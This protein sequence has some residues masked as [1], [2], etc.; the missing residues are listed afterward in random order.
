[1]RDG[2]A[3]FKQPHRS[4]V[5][6]VP[7]NSLIKLFTQV[8]VL[9]AHKTV[10]IDKEILQ[11]CAAELAAEVC[12]SSTAEQLVYTIQQLLLNKKGQKY[13]DELDRLLLKNGKTKTAFFQCL[14]ANWA[15]MHSNGTVTVDTDK[16]QAA[17]AYIDE[18]SMT[19]SLHH[20]CARVLQLLYKHYFSKGK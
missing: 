2:C 11:S 20:E 10:L 1:M 17:C 6:G 14:K 9:P 18:H 8:E 19:T 3:P 15:V 12:D 5:Y 13:R 16:L 7:L 4:K